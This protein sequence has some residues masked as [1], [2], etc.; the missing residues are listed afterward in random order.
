MFL[1][2]YNLSAGLK[3]C[4]P[5]KHCKCF[6][7]QIPDRY[8]VTNTFL[9]INHRYLFA[10][11]RRNHWQA[12]CVF[13]TCRSLIV[14]ATYCRYCLTFLFIITYTKAVQNSKGKKTRKTTEVKSCLTFLFRFQ[15]IIS[16]RHEVRLSVRISVRDVHLYFFVIVVR[17][18]LSRDR[19]RFKQW[20][21]AP[22]PRIN[23]YRVAK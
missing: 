19:Q 2:R 22:G 6:V 1:D 14:I 9:S 17:C 3:I 23:R 20:F 10:M 7:T 11:K 18:V 4:F 8:L 12:V 13:C 15:P 16:N 21:P 5:L